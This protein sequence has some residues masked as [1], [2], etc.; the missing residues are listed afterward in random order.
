[1]QLLSGMLFSRNT[2]VWVLGISSIFNVVLAAE[3]R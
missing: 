2:P 1:L 3:Q